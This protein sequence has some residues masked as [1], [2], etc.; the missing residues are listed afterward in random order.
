MIDAITG[1]VKIVLCWFLNK[2]VDLIFP[3]VLWLLDQIPAGLRESIDFAWITNLF[4]GLEVFMPV[5]QCFLMWMAYLGWK[6]AYLVFRSL[7][8]LLRG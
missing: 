5:R 1:G 2:I 4:E 7:F 6:T 3:G 8:R